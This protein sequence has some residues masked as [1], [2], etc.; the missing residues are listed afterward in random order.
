MPLL[1]E[2]ARDFDREVQARGREYFRRGAARITGGSNHHV[3]ATVLGGNRYRVKINW[4]EGGEP[5]YDCSCPFFR[6]RGGQPCKHLWAALLQAEREGLLTEGEGEA[7][8][9]GWEGEDDEQAGEDFEEG[10]EAD[11]E[12]EAPDGTTVRVGSGPSRETGEDS[13]SDGAK[14]ADSQWKRQLAKL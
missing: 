14:A 11:F 5:E 7:E 4:D 6:D 2:F 9:E 1:E 8:D 10:N 3:D 13:K 12:D